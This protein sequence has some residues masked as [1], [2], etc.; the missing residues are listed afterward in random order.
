MKTR[1]VKIGNSR[2]VRIPKAL[3]EHSGIGEAVELDVE[4]RQIIIRQASRPRTGWDAAF[5]SMAAHGDDRLVD[6]GVA[7]K[8]RW[9]E[10]EWEW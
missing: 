10:A 7:G 5:R 4:D 6:E 3:L 9:D 8:T 2:G 1:I